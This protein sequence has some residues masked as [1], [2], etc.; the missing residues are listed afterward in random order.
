M[1]RQGGELRL[2]NLGGGRQLDNAQRKMLVELFRD[3]S[4]TVRK[5]AAIIGCH[6]NT[7]YSV[8]DKIL[9][10]EERRSVMTRRASARRKYR[11]RPNLFAPS[12]YPT[13][14][15]GYLGFSWRTGGCRTSGACA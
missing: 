9:S 6:M 7:V 14:N 15:S 3:S 10:P 4:R 12:R 8:T 11:Y 13:R 2:G 5:I 1:R